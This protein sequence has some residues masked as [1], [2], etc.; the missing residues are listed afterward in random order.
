[1]NEAGVIH[2]LH[3]LSPGGAF[4]RQIASCLFS[5]G[6]VFTGMANVGSRALFRLAFGTHL[7]VS[8]ATRQY[9]GARNGQLSPR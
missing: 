6:R 4:C 1:M 2:R 7:G 5:A 9:V 3:V 8:D